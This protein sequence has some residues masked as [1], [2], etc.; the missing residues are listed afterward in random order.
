MIPKIRRRQRAWDIAD[1]VVSRFVGQARA[2]DLTPQQR[3]ILQ[4]IVRDLVVDVR[5]AARRPKR[6]PT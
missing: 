4:Y 2:T 5:R 1:K 6:T 3:I